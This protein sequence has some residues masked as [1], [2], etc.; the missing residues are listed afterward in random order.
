MVGTL[1][2]PSLELV[3]HDLRPEALIYDM[4]L[5]LQMKKFN[6]NFMR[7]KVL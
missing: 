7:I 3:Y 5:Q 1:T 4:R 6:P 2:L